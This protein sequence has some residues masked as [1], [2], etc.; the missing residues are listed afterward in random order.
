M[1]AYTIYFIFT[2]ST[3][4]HLT[5][6][7]PN[8]GVLITLH[9]GMIYVLATAE[10]L[11]YRY[12]KYQ[13]FNHNKHSKSTKNVCKLTCLIIMHTENRTTKYT[14]VSLLL[15]P[16]LHAFLNTFRNIRT[17]LFQFGTNVS[18]KWSLVPAVTCYRDQNKPCSC[19]YYCY[20]QISLS[21]SPLYNTC[22]FATL[23]G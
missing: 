4:H 19:V 8:T 13:I 5:T 17:K 2:N 10:P 14:L 6:W 1:S 7:P 12:N 22:T 20:C 16:E 23:C 9:R 11:N 18:K 3:K 15:C 21:R